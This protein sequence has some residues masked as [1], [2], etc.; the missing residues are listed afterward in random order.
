MLCLYRLAMMTRNGQGCAKDITKGIEMLKEAADNGD[1]R[2]RFQIGIDYYTGKDIDINY[3]HAVKCLES[4]LTDK[5]LFEDARRNIYRILSTCYRFGR[6]VNA[7]ESKANEYFSEA[8][9]YGN[10]DAIKIHEWLFTNNV[11]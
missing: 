7:N 5:N 6:G 4:A 8:T 2:A 9:R 1:C 10:S 3:T 11:E